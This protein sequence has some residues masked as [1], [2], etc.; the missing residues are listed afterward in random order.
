MALATS[1]RAQLAFKTEVTAGTT[2]GGNGTYLRMTGESLDFSISTVT[3]NEIVADRQT[4]DIIQTGG[5]GSGGF[6]F[7]LSHKEYDPFIESTLQGA[8]TSFAYTPAA[9]V[10]TTAGCT[11]TATNITA[12]V[13]GAFTGIP[14]GS[15]VRYHKV[16]N[17]T[18]YY[19]LVTA[20][21]NSILTTSLL[22]K[23]G[24]SIGTVASAATDTLTHISVKNGTTQKHFS[25]EVAHT[26]ITKYRLYKGFSPNKMSLSL[27]S[28]S[29]VTGS[30]DFTGMTEVVAGATTMGALSASQVF[31]PMNAVTGVGTILENGAALSGT[32]MKSLSLDITNNLRGLDG[33]GTLGFVGI[34]S[35]SLEVKGSISVYF[36]DTTLIDKAINNIKTSLSFYVT[37][38][39][40]NGYGIHLPSVKYVNAK[41]SAGGLNQDSMVDLE[42]TAYKDATLGSTI[43]I[44]RI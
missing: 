38:D 11:M 22:S 42:F 2:P 39:A 18:S 12:G 21:N 41:T 37:D 20:N 6:N 25:L 17:S 16:S 31:T 23:A 44:S 40:G 36:A 19:G 26:D 10:A 35:G 7:E 4:S 24:V 15:W 30:F 29:I 14:V 9:Y 27:Q 8:W 33:I 28:G 34:A 32:Y 5:S 43:I 13:T 1:N 3:S